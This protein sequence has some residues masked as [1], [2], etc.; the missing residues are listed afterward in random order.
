MISAL[1]RTIISV[2]IIFII[3]IVIMVIM[4]NNKEP[5]KQDNNITNVNTTI[6]S[7]TEE[8]RIENRAIINNDSNV[9]NESNSIK[10]SFV[11]DNF[12]NQEKVDAPQKIEESI[13]TEKEIENAKVGDRVLLTGEGGVY[14]SPEGNIFVNDFYSNCGVKIYLKTAEGIQYEVQADSANAGDYEELFKSYSPAD[15]SGTDIEN[16]YNPCT[17]TLSGTV[18]R[19]VYGEDGQPLHVYELES[20]KVELL[21]MKKK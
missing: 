13:I 2:I 14:R 20:A 3:I 18:S 8:N 21:K 17:M 16:R 5:K 4:V 9:T 19:I 12:T 15:F 1:Y 7:S 6:Q 11:E 10:N